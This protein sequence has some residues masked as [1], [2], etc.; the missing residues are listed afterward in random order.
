[1]KT[2]S[3]Q[4]HIQ[5]MTGLSW[6]RSI[7]TLV[8]LVLGWCSASAAITPYTSEAGFT[9]YL[10]TGYYFND[11][12]DAAAG[13]TLSFS[14]GSFSY[15]ISRVGGVG[16][17]G[18][19]TDFVKSGIG[20]GDAVSSINPGVSL[21]ITFTGG[22]P[23]AVGG[24]FFWTDLSSPAKVVTGTVRIQLNDGT[25]QNVSSTAPGSSGN[26][27]FGGFTTDGTPFTSLTFSLVGYTS[28][29]RFATLD[30]FY[31]GSAVPEPGGW[32]AAGFVA[33]FVIGRTGFGFLRRKQAARQA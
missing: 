7:P 25:W 15:T 8:F 21:V 32:V 4:D 19:P 6:G 5:A 18:V 30:N 14:Q 27:G 2:E 33:L 29:D 16:V 1:M 23:T 26:V 24:N 12:T 22:N 3:T 13:D 17:S 20:Q 28:G 31:V 10:Q 9:P 11:F